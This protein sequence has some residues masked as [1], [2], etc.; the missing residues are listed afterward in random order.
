[1]IITN[2]SHSIITETDPLKKIEQIAR[3][4]YKSEDKITDGSDIKMVNALIAR[5]HTAMLEHA[6]IILDVSQ[7]IYYY[8]A[9]RVRTIQAIIS[10]EHP[11][12]KRL[13]L[14]FSETHHDNKIRY[15]I[16]GNIRAWY[17]YFRYQLEKVYE[18]LFDTINGVIR[19]ILSKDSVNFSALPEMDLLTDNKTVY[20]DNF[21]NVVSDINTLT[22]NE[23]MIH[24]DLSVKFTVDRG[25]THELVRMREASFAQESTRYCNY[26]KDKF[27]NE[28][29][30]VR[31][32]FEGWD[33]NRFTLWQN[34]CEN[35]EK[36]YFALLAAGATPQEARDVLPTS[37]KSEIAVTA[38]LA[39]WYHILNLRACDATGPAHPQMHEIMIPLLDEFKISHPFA[40]GALTT[41]NEV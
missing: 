33:E 17:E 37:V 39:E 8:V 10:P 13:Y 18:P 28:I 16:S 5:K 34:A 3:I 21:I 12:N 6:N 20:M 15:L 36:S 4:C 38:N 24:E 32:C 1:M 23:R 27:G 41:R 22:D 19:N 7:N 25:V 29:T 11:V 26:S 9:L 30:V 14:R 35:A 2:A 40:F 31:P